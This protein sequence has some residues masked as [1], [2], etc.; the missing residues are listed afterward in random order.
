MKNDYGNVWWYGY[1][2][3]GAGNMRYGWIWEGNFTYPSS[4]YTAAYRCF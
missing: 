2:R 1:A 4:Y 3:G